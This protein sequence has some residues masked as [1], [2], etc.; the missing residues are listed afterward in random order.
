[1]ARFDLP[2]DLPNH[3]VPPSKKKLYNGGGGRSGSGSG[4]DESY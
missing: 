3:L 2:D 4:T 1:M